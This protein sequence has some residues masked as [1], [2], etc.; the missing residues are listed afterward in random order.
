LGRTR[1]PTAILELRGA[2]KRN[3]NRRRP[4]EP[5]VTAPLPN[6]PR[7]LT[8]HVRLIWSEMQTNGFWLTSADKFIVEIAATLIAWH[9]DGNHK[10]TPLLI[11]TL[12]KLGFAPKSRAALNVKDDSDQQ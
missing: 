12:A 7:R 10:I 1:T 9:R 11:A 4:N 2:F 8:K 3:P 6:A 5:L